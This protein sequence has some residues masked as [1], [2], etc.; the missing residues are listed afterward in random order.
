MNQLIRL[1]NIIKEHP[2]TCIT[3]LTLSNPN[4]GEFIAEIIKNIP[5]FNTSIELTLE[6]SNNKLGAFYKAPEKNSGY[7]YNALKIPFRYSDQV[8]NRIRHYTSKALIYTDDPNMKC[9]SCDNYLNILGDD[10]LDMWQHKYSF[11][12]ILREYKLSNIV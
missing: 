4:H 12:F 2:I 10:I 5:D 3:G 1:I 9:S 11:N 6:N 8:I 7:T